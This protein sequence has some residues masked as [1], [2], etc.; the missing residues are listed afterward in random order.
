MNKS[1]IVGLIVAA[2]ES[3]KHLVNSSGKRLREPKVCASGDDC[4]PACIFE[5]DDKRNYWCIDFKTPHVKV[6]WEWL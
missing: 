2:A 6:G 1:V 5:D 3:R 4:D